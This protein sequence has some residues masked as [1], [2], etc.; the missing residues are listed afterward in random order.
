MPRNIDEFLR[1]TEHLIADHT[2]LEGIGATNSVMT[3]LTSTFSIPTGVVTQIDF[4]NVNSVDLIDT[5][6]F[7]VPMG[8]NPERLTIPAGLDGIYLGGAAIFY[9]AVAAGTVRTM[10]FAHYRPAATVISRI[11]QSGAPTTTT[12][13]GLSGA[14]IFTNV[15]VGDYFVLDGTQDS[16][17][18]VNVGVGS[19]HSTVM[20]LM[21]IG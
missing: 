15:L 4:D 16:G 3:A 12:G 2:G 1:D 7:H 11:G 20:W 14:R 5:D 17:G 18:P 6:Q 8:A 9:D 10:G 19:P 21:K 13:I